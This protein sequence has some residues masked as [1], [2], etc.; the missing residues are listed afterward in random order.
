VNSKYLRSFIFG[1][2]CVVLICSSRATFAAPTDACSL[3]TQDQVSTILGVKVGAGK[4]SLAKICEW[5]AEGQSGSKAVKVS[6]TIQ[7]PQAFA[8]AKAP[9]GN[10]ITK[11]PVSGVGDEAVSGTMPNVATTLTVRK[12]D[13]YFAVH[14]YP[15]SDGDDIK[16]KEKN[17]ALQILA[18]H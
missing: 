9:A 17:I 15:F 7:T 14:I 11:T 6:V 16:T 5:T 2:F 8:Y 18:A 12:G 1:I 4:S 10:G 13:F 3:L